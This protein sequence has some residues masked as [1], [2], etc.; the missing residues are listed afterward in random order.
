[1]D[2]I[3]KLYLENA[4][5]T[6]E[7]IQ[8]KGLDPKKILDAKMSVE[9]YLPWVEELLENCKEKSVY[10]SL[11]YDPSRE[12]PAPD[13]KWQ[14]VTGP[15]FKTNNIDQK[16]KVYEL[17]HTENKKRTV[18]S[19]ISVMLGHEIA[20]IFQKI[21][22]EA[23]PLTLFNRINSDRRGIYAEGG[24]MHMQ[25]IISTEAFG[26][27]SIPIPHYVRA[28]VCRLRGGDYLDCVS[29]FYDSAYKILKAQL[30]AGIITDKNF[31]KKVDL[32]LKT[33]IGSVKRLF[34]SATGF[35]GQSGILT[36]SD[37]T[38]YLEQ[39]LL[40]DKLKAIGKEKY[41][42]LGINLETITSLAKLGFLDAAKIK[43]PS[44]YALKI[45]DKIKDGYK[46]QISENSPADELDKNPELS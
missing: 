10:P 23:L 9:Q 1:A 31:Q 46:L 45:W 28:M 7:N 33:A 32:R 16:R 34:N 8:K 15:E 42:Y 22:R 29:A 3:E 38:A 41:A 27:R 4:L 40:M 36:R 2:Q 24:A 17:G 14:V 21:N 30:D 20:H 11:E 25:D 43:T 13:G 44:R 6:N 12:N 39:L 5:S 18:E 37:A 35:S 26:T 19:V